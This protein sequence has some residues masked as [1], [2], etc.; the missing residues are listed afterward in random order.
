[1]QFDEFSIENFKGIQSACLNLRTSAKNRVFTL[2]GLNESGKTTLLEAIHSFSP[3]P[4]SQILFSSA[5]FLK[6]SKDDLIPR[7]RISDFS[8]TVSVTATVTMDDDDVSALRRFCRDEL[9]ADYPPT[10]FLVLSRFRI[11]TCTR[12]QSTRM[13]IQSGI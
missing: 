2:I 7:H 8:E 4:D 5:N 6:T 12:I 9:N 11:E 1:M 10:T 13:P 3:D